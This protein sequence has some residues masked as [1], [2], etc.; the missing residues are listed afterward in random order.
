MFYFFQKH[1][2]T[3]LILISAAVIIAFVL[4]FN[5]Q[6]LTAL[7]DSGVGRIDGQSVSVERFTETNY[8]LRFDWSMRRGQRPPAQLDQAFEQQAWQALVL[9]RQA[10]KLGLSVSGEEVAAVILQM[11]DFQTDGRFDDKKYNDFCKFTLVANRVSTAGLENIIRRQLLLQKLANLIGSTAK[12]SPQEIKRNFREFHER[13]VIQYVSLAA[14]DFKKSIPTPTE[15]D[16]KA[17]FAANA[18]S[19]MA[20][21]SREVEFIKID[22]SNTKSPATPGSV[23]EEEVNAALQQI[24][25]IVP[26]PDGK[27][28]PEA[29]AKKAVREELL[30][31]KSVQPVRD[32]AQ[33]IAV[34]LVPE[35]GKTA[36]DFA[37]VAASENLPVSLSG[38]FT[39]KQLPKGITNPQFVQAA[40]AL[41]RD[42]PVSDPIEDGNGGY[43]I[44]HLLKVVPARPMS[45]DEAKPEIL[46]S[47]NQAST[48]KLLNQ[49]GLEAQ[50]RIRESLAKGK[51][52]EQAAADLKLPVKTLPALSLIEME[53]SMPN[54]SP[55]ERM[56]RQITFQ[57]L[58]GRTTDF[59]AFENGGF[60]A[61][62]KSRD[63]P[64]SSDPEKIDP[65]FVSE[66]TQFL[67]NR[68]FEDWVSI[69]MKDSPFPMGPSG[70]Q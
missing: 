64:A 30:R 66:M 11:K 43:H 63:L 40:F 36:P 27:A 42:N 53:K 57:T 52:F 38:L 58:P 14:E 56:V 48:F 55:V 47:L 70:A 15:N 69:Q 7:R 37:R 6:S 65:R 10:Q 44:L 25:G 2:R 61:Y 1:S 18:S 16:L 33:K 20:P 8:E 17:F 32:R 9:T 41:A 54:A 29:S 34:S 4:L 19:F 59:S 26:G 35:S 31:R 3:F 68:L 45:F 51:S 62:V 24:G 46:R 50:T 28:L 67:R 21:E 60:L 23:S 12:V 13:A 5:I 22:P 49:T 39:S